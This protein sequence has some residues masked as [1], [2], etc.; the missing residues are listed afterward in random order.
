MKDGYME[1][2]MQERSLPGHECVSPHLRPQ[3]RLCVVEE[4]RSQH[5]RHRFDVLQVFAN[6]PIVRRV[7]AVMNKTIVSY[8]K[9]F[10]TTLRGHHDQVGLVV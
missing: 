9:T 8:A 10:C 3:D 2:E 5:R 4:H 1:V 7:P 6:V